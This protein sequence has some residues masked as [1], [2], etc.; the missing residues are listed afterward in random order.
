MEVKVQK[1]TEFDWP[2]MDDDENFTNVKVSAAD[3]RRNDTFHQIRF[4]I[5]TNVV[6]STGA[7]SANF[8]AIL[9]NDAVQWMLKAKRGKLW[10]PRDE[11]TAEQREARRQVRRRLR[12]AAAAPA[13]AARRRLGPP[14]PLGM[15]ALDPLEGEVRS[16]AV[17]VF[18]QQF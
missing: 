10:I 15:A 1:D 17:T 4:L 12:R 3:I 2:H 5:S 6:A 13:A 16:V 11:E 18:M 8:V 9:N 14:P 7:P